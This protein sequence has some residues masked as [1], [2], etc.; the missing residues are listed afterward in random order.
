MTVSDK[1]FLKDIDARQLAVVRLFGLDM[2]EA[3]NT[4]GYR[5]IS[6]LVF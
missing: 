6:I 5:S 3:W 2:E 4:I 1:Y